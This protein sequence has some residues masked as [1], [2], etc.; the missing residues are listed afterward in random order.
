MPVKIFKA[1]VRV[2]YRP[3]PKLNK[4]PSNGALL[5]YSI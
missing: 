4:T 3:K 5:F 2:S 1:R